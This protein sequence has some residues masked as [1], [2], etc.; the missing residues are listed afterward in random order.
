M[1]RILLF[2][3]F[4]FPFLGLAQIKTIGTPNIRNYPKTVYQAGNQNWGITQDLN[5]FMYFANNEGV[6]QFDGFHW[7]LI[8]VNSLVRSVLVNS[9]NRI[10][11]GLPY[12]FGV[13]EKTQTG[14]FVFQSLLD[15]V[16][17]E[18]RSFSDIWK[19][20]EING[21]IVFQ[22]FEK[23]FIYNGAEI[24]V[25]EPTNKFHFSFKVGERLLIQEPGVG[26]F[27]VFNGFIDKV[28][29][30]EPLKDFRILSILELGENE[31][32]IGTE[33]SDLYY[34]QQGKLSVW[35][36]E[37]NGAVKSSKLYSA[38]TLFDNYFA[39]GTVLNGVFIAD[40][41]GKIIQHIN[42]NT[43]LGNNTVLSLLFDKEK[44]LWLG[45]DNGIGYVQ[46]NSPISYIN[47]Y[48]GLGTGYCSRVFDGNLYLGTNQ[49][50]FIKP[51]HDIY[52]NNQEFELVENTKGQV[53][54]LEIFDGQLLCGHNLGTFSIKNK[55]ATQISDVPG[56][57]TYIPLK[58]DP[59]FLI[60]GHYDGITI[61]EKGSEGWKFRNKVKGFSESSRFLFE[62]NDGEIWMSHGG[63]GVYRLT[64]NESLDSITNVKLY[65]YTEGL[66]SNTQNILFKLAE[67]NYISTIDGVYE[68]DKTADTF[69]TADEINK[70]F[71][72]KD[73]IR[74][75]SG[76]D[77]GNI[78]FISENESGV[79]R[80][81]EDLTYTKITSPFESLNSHYVREFEFIYPRN[82]DQTF[83]GIDDGFA[84]YSSKF[85]KSFVQEF[86]SFITKVELNYIDSVIYP[87]EKSEKIYELP[88]QRNSFRFHYTAPFYENL[89]DLRFSYLLENYSEEWSDL[90]VDI[91]K[92][93]T[94]LPFGKYTFK[95]KA[96]NN[97]GI[98]S[99]IDEFEFIILPPWYQ[100]TLA[101]SLYTLFILA[102]IL[103]LILFLRYRMKLSKNRE[104]QKHIKELQ[105]KEK[106][107]QH[108]AVVA[109]KEIMKL[110][111]DKLHAEMIHRDKELAN[112]TNSIIQKNKFL[113]KLNDEL[114]LLQN[115]TDDASVRTKIAII[116]KRISKETES[117]QKKVFETYF[118][119]VHEEF[120]ERLK[121]KFP[122][123]SPKDLRLCA[124]IRMNIPT[125]E[126][127][128]L[129][130]IS[131]R[132]VEITRYR[133]RKKL[134]LSRE[135]NLSTF[136]SGI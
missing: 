114:R 7:D 75:V 33:S 112:Q 34:Y 95:I 93:F 102:L 99:S 54:S 79:L 116:K 90:T 83:F 86:R 46:V 24:D 98:E 87:Y 76:D 92:D 119:E 44:N 25:F 40:K 96:L 20:H 63:K 39:F 23:L 70:L 58:N 12:D 111:N 109:E 5:G 101:Y 72:S 100:T 69:K 129:L 128:T 56:G 94:N 125:K 53:W 117:K 127:A 36:T 133:L 64:I 77:E 103:F 21:K 71:G 122:Q 80:K 91:Y 45:L 28:P 35:D 32:L 120:F 73:R 115:S 43:N 131:D 130:N 42:K 61:L 15:L 47:A 78:W 118:D 6:L 126:I 66:P 134:E 30:A 27:E 113:R 8:N 136:L 82:E 85:P 57:W 132:G 19:I 41:N 51:F 37:V 135:I 14:T 124:Y 97:Y 108:Q 9:E 29:W 60:G 55:T 1:Y 88:F 74:E 65:G 13:L 17:E 123:L 67:E 50:L 48:G 4:S 26:L 68:Y 110:R 52:Q 22:S 104:R 105:K 62:D 59:G 31:L 3:L 16:P 121:K 11:V 38:T 81:N 84:H 10:F 18:N 106:I 2:I 89:T 49:G 107:I